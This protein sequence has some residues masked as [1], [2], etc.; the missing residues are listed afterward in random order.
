MNI[1]DINNLIDQQMKL[2]ESN[3]KIVEFIPQ[4]SSTNNF[5]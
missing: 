5:S 1:N 4:E 2:M 3:K